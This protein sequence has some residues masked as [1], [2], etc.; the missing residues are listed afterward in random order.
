MKTGN[1]CYIVPAKDTLRR[2]DQVLSMEERLIV[3]SLN[4]TK[5]GIL[6]ASVRIAIVMKA[7][8]VLNIVNGRQGEIQDI[9]LD[10]RAERSIPDADG[11]VTLKYPPLLLFRPEKKT[12]LTSR[13]Y[14]SDTIS[15]TVYRDKENE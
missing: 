7:M 11:Y 12:R 1:Q 5:T 14:S 13:R 15:R 2:N 4:D 3:A 8:V 10:E 6:P 9:I